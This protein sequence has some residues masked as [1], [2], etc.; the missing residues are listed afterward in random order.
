MFKLTGTEGEKG[1][2]LRFEVVQKPYGPLPTDTME[3]GP[4]HFLGIV[5][6]ASENALP[7][8]HICGTKDEHYCTIP[9]LSRSSNRDEAKQILLWYESTHPLHS[10]ITRAITVQQLDAWRLEQM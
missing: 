9:Y 6:T 8:T 4:S 3:Y 2:K 10:S 1:Y 5:S 7:L